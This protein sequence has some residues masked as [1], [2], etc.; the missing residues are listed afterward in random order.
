MTHHKVLL[1]V[2][3]W[4]THFMSRGDVSIWVTLEHLYSGEKTLCTSS[5]LLTEYR[6]TIVYW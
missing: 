3:Q 2:S 1:L 4:Y 6:E 5:R